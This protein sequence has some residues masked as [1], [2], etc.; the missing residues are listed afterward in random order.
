MLAL[1][2]HEPHFSIL[3]EQVLTNNNNN[4]RTCGQPGH[5]ASEC[6][7]ISLSLSRS[8]AHLFGINAHAHT[9]MRYWQHCRCRQGQTGRERRQADAKEALPVPPRSGAARIPAA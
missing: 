4:C 9:Q 8:L 1:A 2:T 3:R 7:G 5:Y 6:K